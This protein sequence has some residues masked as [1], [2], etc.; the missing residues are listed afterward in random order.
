VHGRRRVLRHGGHALQQRVLPPGQHVHQQPVCASGLRGVRADCVPCEQRV[1]QPADRWVCL[2]KG[3]GAQRGSTAG[4]RGVR[5]AACVS[6]SRP[7]R[8]CFAATA[9]VC[10]QSI[11]QFGCGQQ[12]CNSLTQT[13]NQFT[14]VCQERFNAACG[15]GSL[16]CPGANVCCPV[17]QVCAFNQCV[18]R[19]SIGRRRQA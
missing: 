15:A 19:N 13:C 2:R 6:R 10:C 17:G 16:W 12:C 11:Q 5:P 3:G 14:Q 8:A 1:R 18:A 4:A 9:G 7:P